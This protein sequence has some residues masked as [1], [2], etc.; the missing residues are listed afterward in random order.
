MP[1]LWLRWSLLPLAA[2]G[3]LPI[4]PFVAIAQEQPAPYTLH[5]YTNLVQIP[6]IV[7]DSSNEPLQH[8]DPTKFS[9]SLDSGPVF[10]PTFV[11][12]QGDDPISLDILLDLSGDENSLLPALRAA[13]PALAPELLHPLDH[14][15][16]YALDC[17][18]I[19]SGNNIPASHDSLQRAVDAAAQAPDL[20]GQKKHSACGGS[21]R[22]W[23]S[24][25]VLEQ[26]LDTLPGRRV[27]LVVSDGYDGH[28]RTQPSALRTYSVY[29]GISIFALTMGL[30][31]VMVAGN[32]IG[33]HLQPANTSVTDNLRL[34][35]E[36]TGGLPMVTT[37][38]QDT[39]AI[40]REFMQLLRGRYIL[41]FPRPDNATAGRHSINVTL[42]KSSAVVRV[43]G[44]SVALPDP[45]VLVD[46]NTVPS[47]P[48]SARFG[49]RHPTNP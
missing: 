14:V 4:R 31:P 11:R 46:P 29:D 44:V 32:G 26:Q 9:I 39:A 7:L 24:L 8:I 21:V 45:A 27:M 13:I 30:P 41:E 22:L 37:G 6:A 25:G 34:L 19:R 12:L 17:I 15:S 43:A 49:K 28:S 38:S 47:A 35:C 36:Q 10:R 16:I 3:C 5:V 18:L 40:L 23:D 42:D 48:T 33:S 2:A 1:A 20:H